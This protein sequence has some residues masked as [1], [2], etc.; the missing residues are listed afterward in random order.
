M[1]LT[2]FYARRYMCVKMKYWFMT[3]FATFD[4]V[5]GEKK[6]KKQMRTKHFCKKE[7]ERNM[8]SYRG[9]VYSK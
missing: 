9:H 2:M 4:R 5:E 6:K 1:W 7:E 3:F 8:G